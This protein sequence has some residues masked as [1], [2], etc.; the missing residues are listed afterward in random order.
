MGADLERVLFVRSGRHK[1]VWAAE[2]ILRSGIFHA[3]LLIDSVLGQGNS[4]RA[5]L[6]LKAAALRRLQLASEAANAIMLVVHAPRAHA[7][8]ARVCIQVEPC[9][10]QPPSASGFLPRLSVRRRA[11]VSVFRGAEAGSAVVEI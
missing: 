5:Q 1:A 6:K 7:G 9:P 2:Q 3:V 10:G 4:G 11:Q 8:F